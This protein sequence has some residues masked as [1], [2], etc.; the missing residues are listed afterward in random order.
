MSGNDEL[1]GT[2]KKSLDQPA[3]DRAVGGDASLA[4]VESGIPADEMMGACDEFMR[5]FRRGAEFTRELMDH[6]ARLRYRLAKVDCDAVA[7]GRDDALILELMDK[8]KRVEKDWEELNR[9]FGDAEREQDEIE[10]RYDDVQSENNDL[11]NTLV[12]S[13]QLHSTMDSDK[14]KNVLVEILI[15]FIGTSIFAVAIVDDDGVLHPLLTEGIAPDTVASLDSKS[16]TIGEVIESGKRHLAPKPEVGAESTS[17][18][19]ASP[20]GCVPLTI[21]RRVI[22]VLLLY[23]F[24]EHKTEW[25]AV[26]E[27]L[28][29]MLGN[30]AAAALVAA[31]LYDESQRNLGKNS[32]IVALL[33]T[34]HLS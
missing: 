31:S 6:N 21:E 19:L 32:E 14:V 8:V 7:K 29:T 5:V 13:L 24:L 3:G 2:T 10:E 11:L 22:G 27:E 9:R 34:N 16:G 30:C 4:G 33:T 15:N 25:A 23:G 17:Q 1:S 28:L 12:S 18:S 20:L 26:D